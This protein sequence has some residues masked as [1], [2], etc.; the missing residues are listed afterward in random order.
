MTVADDFYELFQGNLWAYGTEE[1]GCARIDNPT[2]TP[3]LRM[4]DLMELHLRGDASQCIA[5][6]GMGIYPMV[7]M[8][9][10]PSP[11]GSTSGFQW[12]VHWGCIDF[13]EGDEESWVHAKNVHLVLQTFGIT[14]WIERSRSKGYHV[15]VFLQDWTD[16]GLVRRA[17]LAACQIVEAPTKE[18][19]PKQEELA[20]G[21]LGNYVRL[22]YPGYLK[23][24]HSTSPTRRVMY[25][26]TGDGTV[27]LE[28]F[29]RMALD[30][31]ASS[32]ALE[33]L[34]SYYKPPVVPLRERAWGGL[35]E[36]RGEP[37]ARLMGKAKIIFEQGPIDNK[38]RGHTLF[39]FACIL[40]EDGRHTRDEAYDLIEDADHRWGKF[41][42]RPDKARYYTAILDK[43]GF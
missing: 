28:H 10:I 18:I 23:R 15:W 17:L 4:R 21:Q 27:P 24:E 37:I 41:F 43:A 1:G 32:A 29:V 2:D 12:R 14:A 8:A 25:A 7:E 3:A 31:R 35:Q 33:K 16:A 30:T 26:P 20:Q 22:P 42:E 5:G 36:Q 38:F 39:K 9:P 34:A 11:A 19:N 13:D 6:E 40:F